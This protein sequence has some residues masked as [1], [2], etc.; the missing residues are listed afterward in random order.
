MS[1][2]EHYIKALTINGQYLNGIYSLSSFYESQGDLEK[3]I[4]GYRMAL[5][6]D[7]ENVEL[8]QHIKELEKKQAY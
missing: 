1:A 7:P 2:E 4:Y 5:Q 6:L 3:A 8:A